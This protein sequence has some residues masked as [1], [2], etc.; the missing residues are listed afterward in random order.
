MRETIRTRDISETIAEFASETGS[1]SEEYDFTLEGVTT[2][3]NTCHMDSFSK[4]SVAQREQ[5]K[6]PT[7]LIDDR[8]TFRQSYKIIPIKT[9]LSSIK[10]DHH[11]KSDPSNIHPIL[12]LDPS[13]TIPVKQHKPKE[14]F[15]LLI[16][17]INKIKALNGMLIGIFSETM[18]ADIKSLIKR[19]YAG[20]FTEPVSIRLFSG[21]TPEIA[22]P[23]RLILHFQE[24]NQDKQLKEVEVGELIIEYIKPVFGSNGLNAMGRRVDKD[25]VD[26]EKFI[27]NTID[28]ATIE[29]R[30]DD[31]KITLWSKK[32]GFVHYDR[33]ILKISNRLRL[34]SLKRVESQVTDQ[35]QNDVEIVIDQKD[36]TQD[37]IGE[38]VHLTSNI[39]HVSGYVANKA[40]LNSKEL[41]IDGVSHNGSRLFAQEAT[42]N[43]HKGILR[44]H[45]AT[46]RL[47]EGGEVHATEVHIDTALGGKVYADKITIGTVRHHL[48]AY[49]SKSIMINKIIGEENLFMIDAQ[50]NPIVQSRLSHMQRDLDSLRD[51]LKKAKLHSEQD[52]P[53]IREKINALKDSIKAFNDLP[54]DATITIK[55]KIHGYNT[56]GFT[57]STQQEISFHT[58]EHLKYAPFYISATEDEIT[59]HP[60]G[61]TIT[62]D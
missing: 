2:Y 43:R 48:K 52:V 3:I 13:S 17:E 41:V 25:E 49:A 32:R 6:D 50:D 53:Q 20:T 59:L 14:L 54:F 37:T 9:A 26:N 60:V 57:L 56:I 44:C 61:V 21:I 19:L 62:I 34:Q 46:I 24:K 38:G 30:E 8:V 23:S 1:K 28:T 15:T 5:Y 27:S 42:I 36:L 51:Q 18:V 58:V 55:E 11:I 4:Y 29:K 16:R 33:S 35:E 10:L 45:K 12:V 7:R 22:R 40:V 47:L 39:I 31:E